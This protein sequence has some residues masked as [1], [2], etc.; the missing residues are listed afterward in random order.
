MPR[1][2]ASWIG[3]IVVL[4]LADADLRVGLHG[5]IVGESDDAVRFRVDE[6]WDFDIYKSM[7]LAVEQ[8]GPASTLMN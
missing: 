8:D 3:K 5:V 2:Y 6:R 1:A 7:I 4:Q